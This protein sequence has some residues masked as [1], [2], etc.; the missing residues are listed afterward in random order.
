LSDNLAVYDPGQIGDLDPA[1]ANRPGYTNAGSLQLYF[2]VRQEHL[3]D[4]LQGSKIITVKPGFYQRFVRPMFPGK[5]G[6]N[7]F[8]STNI[9]S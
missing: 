7:C 4:C 8:S 2:F 6:Q 9:A 5:E 3:D 1:L